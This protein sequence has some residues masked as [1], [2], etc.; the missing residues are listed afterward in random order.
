PA[1]WTDEV[2]HKYCGT[3]DAG[4]AGKPNK[5]HLCGKCMAIKGRQMQA[6]GGDGAHR[7]REKMGWLA[8]G[9]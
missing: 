6:A 9:G 4:R 1:E 5:V 2:A 3:L 8:G 7:R